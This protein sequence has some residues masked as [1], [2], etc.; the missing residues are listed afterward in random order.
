MLFEIC[1]FSTFTAAHLKT[2][3]HKNLGA[4][5]EAAKTDATV[6]RGRIGG[7]FTVPP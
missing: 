2:S 3:A 5:R 6:H 7:A 1:I 4:C